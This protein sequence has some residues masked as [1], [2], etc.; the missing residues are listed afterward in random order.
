MDRAT[1]TRPGLDRDTIRA[2]LAGLEQRV[3]DT[4]AEVRRRRSGEIDERFRGLYVA[5]AHVDE[6]LA[7]PASPH[8]R[9]TVLAPAPEGSRLA[10]LPLHT[11]IDALDTTLLVIAAAPDL[12]RRFEPL[13]AYLNDD[14]SQRRATVGLALTLAGLAS[15]DSGGRARLARQGRLQRTA[16]LTV[17]E[18]E[19]P[20]LTRQLLVP[21]RVTAF[22]LGDDTP[23]AELTGRVRAP[24]P[25]DG[26]TT[27]QLAEAL[28]LGAPLTYLREYRGCDGAATAAGA[29]AEVGRPVVM[30]D[31]QP[32][33]EEVGPLVA[34]ATREAALR[35][36]VLTAGPLEA[37]RGPDLGEWHAR[38]RTLTDGPVP[39]VL[40]GTGAWDPSWS[41]TVPLV[42]DAD[43]TTPAVRTAAAATILPH[44]ALGDDA[45]ARALAPFQLGSR[46]TQ[47]AAQTALIHARLEDRA[48]TEDDL[49]R[50]ARAQNA[51]ELERLARRVPPGARWEDLVL[52][53]RIEAQVRSI[54]TRWRYRDRVLDGWGVNA[55]SR[56]AG[57]VSALFAGPSGT[58][59]TLSGEVIAAELRLDLYLVDLSQVI[60]KYIGETSK[61]LDRIFDAADRVDGVLL[62]DEA[63]ALFGKRS[64]VSDS[65]DRYA[66]VEVAYLLQRMEA[67]SGIAIL[68]TNLAGNLDEAFLR[69][70]DVI[71]DFLAPDATLRRRL[72]ASKLP[73]G[74][75]R[76]DDIDLDLLAERFALTGSEIASI[77]TAAAFDAAAGDQPVSMALLVRATVAEHRKLQRALSPSDL[78]ELERYGPF[79]G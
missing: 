65:R 24:S 26:V 43:R 79:T 72:W 16:L 5:P 69:R 29:A 64:G 54:V 56:R 76:S 34:A 66:N 49:R 61:N 68:T 45:V 78:R 73:P 42:L 53:P 6:L 20:L 58:G 44:D 3:R 15:D 38:V 67:F 36:A 9:L 21:D 71:A 50:G 28:R 23:D 22:L 47:R 55:G 10:L 8:P 35:G 39:T 41:V 46:A 33:E 2:A 70:L 60:D 52:P 12:D 48:P 63:D 7:A 30:V 40:V 4:V 19:R 62:F 14:V 51:V 31:L 37:L 13:Y 11:G 18:P 17:T 25:L 57:G 32:G 1:P 77:V 59:K 74:L 27:R 75:P